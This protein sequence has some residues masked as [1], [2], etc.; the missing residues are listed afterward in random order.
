MGA[1]A[2]GRVLVPGI[3]LGEREEFVDGV[4]VSEVELATGVEV[5]VVADD[6]AALIGA[7]R[8]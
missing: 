3:A 1:G 6:P 4:D 8:S 5:V 7:I 2:K